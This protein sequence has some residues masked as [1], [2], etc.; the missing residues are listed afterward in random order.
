ML[1]VSTAARL[2]DVHSTTG[3]F[4]G[5]PPATRSDLAGRGPHR[6]GLAPDT[7]LLPEPESWAFRSHDDAFIMRTWRTDASTSRAS[8]MSTSPPEILPFVQPSRTIEFEAT[9]AGR[10]YR[11]VIEVGP[12]ARDEEPLPPGMAI[13]N[14]TIFPCDALQVSAE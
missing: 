7:T 6:T 14:V 13:R 11:I 8:T 12:A 1:T 3:R 5:Q 2:F 10:T 4:P 9:R